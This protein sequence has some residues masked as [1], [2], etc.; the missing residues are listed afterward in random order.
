MIRKTDSS[1]ARFFRMG[2]RISVVNGEWFV[3]LREG[4][5]GPFGCREEAERRLR[6]LLEGW[7]LGTSVTTQQ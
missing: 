2:D 5:E 4:E 3:T 1:D 6:W 7:G